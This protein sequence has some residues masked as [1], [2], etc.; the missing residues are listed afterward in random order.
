MVTTEATDDETLMAGQ[1]QADRSWTQPQNWAVTVLATYSVTPLLKKTLKKFQL[2]KTLIPI[3]DTLVSPSH[4]RRPVLETPLNQPPNAEFRV[5]YHIQNTK[6][7]DNLS[8]K[9]YTGCIVCGRS[10]DAIKAENIDNYMRRSTPRNESEYVTTLRREAYQNG[11]NVGSILF[12]PPAVLQA[13]PCEGTQ[14]S[15]T[16]GDRK[17]SQERLLPIRTFIMLVKTD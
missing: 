7:Y 13:A 5:S 1:A 17:F 10:V 14:Y 3:A 12:L 2:C 9:R 4:G 11:L 6:P 8:T 15:T 16:A